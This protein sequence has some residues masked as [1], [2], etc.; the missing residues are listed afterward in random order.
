MKTVKVETPCELPPEPKFV[1]VDF[2]S[3]PECP[4]P[5][6]ICFKLDQALKL[7]I[8]LKKSERWIRQVK[9]RCGK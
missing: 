8:R 5:Y 1:S 2:D 4:V 9:V 7:E 6:V 3:L